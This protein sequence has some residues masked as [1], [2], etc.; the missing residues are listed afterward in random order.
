MWAT[1]RRYSVA[2]WGGGMF[3]WLHRGSNCPLTRAMDGC[4]MRPVPLAHASQS[5]TSLGWVRS[6]V[7]AVVCAVLRV[8]CCCNCGLSIVNKAIVIILLLLRSSVQSFRRC[9]W[10][11][12]ESSPTPTCIDTNGVQR[13]RLPLT[14]RLRR[15][16]RNVTC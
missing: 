14:I 1:G 7:T 4:I 13:P 6:C 11:K 10:I 15:Q 12:L 3:C 9:G 2:D 16:S 5:P 8:G